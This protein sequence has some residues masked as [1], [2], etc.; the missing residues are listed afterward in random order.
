MKKLDRLGWAA[1][2]AFTW[3]GVRIGIRTND[4]DLLNRI[5]AD[6][7][8]ERKTTTSVVVERLYSIVIARSQR[9]SV[10]GFHLLYA[11]LQ[12]LERT[13]NL[14]QLLESLES[15][16]ETYIAHAARSRVFIH[17]GVVAWKKRA[18]ILPGRSFTGKSTLVKEFLRA[19]AQYFS[20]EFAVLDKNGAV[21][22]FPRP[23]SIRIGAPEN[24][25]R[26][27]FTAAELGTTTGKVPLPVAMVVLARYTTGANWRPKILT[28]GQGI[29][30]LMEHSVGARKQ[31]EKTLAA[32][33][34][35]I[36]RAH[37]LR[38][39]RGESRDT[40]KSILDQMESRMPIS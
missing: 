27:R 19:G 21:H 35:A 31:P 26:K 39:N 2:I 11:D 30:A 18:I 24:G 9:R 15:D 3:Y 36:A 1:G 8:A 13:E 25:Q 33:E 37:V 17:A 4:R 40:V 12:R 29:L 20:D 7:P 23:I 34:K 28:Q 10:R 16:L 38:G 5:L 6:F 32:L 22:A 14:D